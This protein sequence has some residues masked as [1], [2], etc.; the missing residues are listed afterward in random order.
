[1]ADS[2]NSYRHRIVVSADDFGV[3]PRANGNI[4]HSVMLGKID[5]VGVMVHG[6]FSDE[7]IMQLVKNGIKLDIHLDILHEFHDNR[8]K[9][10]SASLRVLEFL[11]K[12]ATGKLSSRKVETDWRSQIEK[13][14]EIFGRN[15]DGINS[16]E[17]VHFFP[18]FFKIALK[19]QA[20][21]S[22]PYM[23]FGDSVFMLHNKPVAHILH[24]LRIINRKKFQ[25]SSA[26]SSGSFISLDWI[27]DMDKFLSNLPK[28]AVEIA[29]HPETADDL[30][31]IKRYF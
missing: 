17:H 14:R 21:Y 10:K 8:K 7:E 6:K 12:I 18:P 28:G 11:G 22:I 9:R 2:Y 16:H 27:K 4:C 19:L 29:C 20:E 24:W 15:P 25:K 5:R 1:M 26:V 13:F 30:E 3:S 31:K 23:R